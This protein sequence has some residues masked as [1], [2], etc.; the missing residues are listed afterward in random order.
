[1]EIVWRLFPRPNV[2]IRNVFKGEGFHFFNS[3]TPKKKV[4]RLSVGLLENIC[5][6]SKVRRWLLFFSVYLMLLSKFSIK[7]FKIIFRVQLKSC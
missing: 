4:Y 7:S 1:M 2:K 6:T 3:P 5:F